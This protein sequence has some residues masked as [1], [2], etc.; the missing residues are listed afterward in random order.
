MSSNGAEKHKEIVRR[1]VEEVWNEGRLDAA[2]EVLTADY[3][4]HPS[5]PRPDRPPDGDADR[6]PE[7]MKRFV[8]MF[9]GAFPDMR[10][11]IE[12]M[13]AEGDKVAVHLV[14]SGT[15]LGELHGLPP[16]GRRIR[17]AGAA[18]HRIA[19]DQIAETYQ[20]VDRLALREQLG[21]PGM[22]DLEE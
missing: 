14:G 6:G 7:P 1:F 18:I 8:Q 17:V 5:T 20:V 10:F 21:A 15:H 4:E 12:Q 9:R 16:T 19:G 2:D 11:D 3:I 13:V 22:G